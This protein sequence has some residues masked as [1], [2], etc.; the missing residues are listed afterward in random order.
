MYV[1]SILQVG[2]SLIPYL[3][4]NYLSCAGINWALRRQKRAGTDTEGQTLYVLLREVSRIGKPIATENRTEVA[5]GWGEA[6]G[7]IA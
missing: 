7:V 1:I 2:L 3:F 5:G 4:I 6:W